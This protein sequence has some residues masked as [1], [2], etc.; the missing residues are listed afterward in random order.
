MKIPF[1]P[2]DF[3]IDGWSINTGLG[4][5]N[6]HIPTDVSKSQ[7]ELDSSTTVVFRAL[8]GDSIDGQ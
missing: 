3:G 6:W 7:F 1:V 8:C 2:K 5:C 4:S